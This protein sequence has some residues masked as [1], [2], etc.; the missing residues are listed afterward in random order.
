MMD[1]CTIYFF[2]IPVK[3]EPN[4]KLNPANIFKFSDVFS[5][6]HNILGIFNMKA[7]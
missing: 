3:T 5:M 7:I 2:D 1:S 4:Y 6:C